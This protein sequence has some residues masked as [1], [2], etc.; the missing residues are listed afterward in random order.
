[1]KTPTISVVI[2]AFNSARFLPAA[3]ES[4]LNQTLPP[5]EVI[6]VDDGSTDNT[7]DAVEPFRDR[8]TYIQRESFG[9][10][11]TRNFGIGLTTGEFIAF[12]DADDLWHPEKLARQMAAFEANPALDYCL[13]YVQA[14]WEDEVAEEGVLLKDHPRAQPIPG[15][16]TVPLM[17]RRTVFERVGLLDET[18][19][20]TDAAD[21]FLRADRAGLVKEMLTDV[22]VLRRVHSNNMTKRLAEPFRKEWLDMV[23]KKLDLERRPGSAAN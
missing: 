6:V 14:F 22:L 20:S 16:A 12:L 17:A 9:P 11:A 5:T 4:I 2:P 1:M 18:L 15:Y 7:A 3:L 19:W 10:A 8:V 23:K 13:T 21:W